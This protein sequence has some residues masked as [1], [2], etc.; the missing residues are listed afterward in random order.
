MSKLNINDYKFILEYYKLSIPKSNKLIKSKALSIISN[1]LCKC[2]K[3]VSKKY[4]LKNE[5][6]PIKLC[7]QSVITNKG[8]NR[9][10]FTCKKKSNIIL[11]KNKTFKNKYS[12]KLLYK[13]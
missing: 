2:I 1:K 8:F 12:K 4:K 13:K 3:K 6:N 7:T 11:S 9:G 10:F 5:A